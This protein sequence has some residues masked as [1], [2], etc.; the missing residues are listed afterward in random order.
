M[1]LHQTIATATE[2]NRMLKAVFREEIVRTEH[3]ITFPSSRV[4]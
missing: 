1:Y 3:M 2:T 4:E